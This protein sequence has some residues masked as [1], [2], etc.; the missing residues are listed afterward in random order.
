MGDWPTITVHKAAA[1]RMAGR[2]ITLL[3]SLNGHLAE[4]EYLLILKDKVRYDGTVPDGETRTPFVEGGE[5][6]LIVEADDE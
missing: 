6:V 1:H 5:R 4:G 3:P 2:P